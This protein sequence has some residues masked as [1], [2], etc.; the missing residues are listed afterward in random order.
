MVS[1][2]IEVLKQDKS[3]FGK[4]IYLVKVTMPPGRRQQPQ[5]WP[6]LT[7]L[8]RFS[9]AAL[10]S[11]W[12][13]APCT[14][15][16]EWEEVHKPGRK[17]QEATKQFVNIWFDDVLE[18]VY[19]NNMRKLLADEKLIRSAFLFYVREQIPQKKEKQADS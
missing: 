6:G 19:G 8:P 13:K 18:G 2:L 1:N 5:K 3:N 4:V 16:R 11:N 17:K 7:V 15:V 10:Q 12:P 14:D 9:S